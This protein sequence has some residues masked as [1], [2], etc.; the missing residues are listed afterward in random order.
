M[1]FAGKGKYAV[2]CSSVLSF[3]CVCFV[4]QNA[5]GSAQ[6]GAIDTDTNTVAVTV[7]DTVTDTFADIDMDIDTDI[8]TATDTFADTDKVVCKYKYAFMLI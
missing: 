2:Y 7:T 4:S 1:H 5:T 3:I 8:D 6:S